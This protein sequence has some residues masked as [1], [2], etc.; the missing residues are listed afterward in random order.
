MK[1][2]AKLNNLRTAPRKVRLVVDLIK[3]SNTEDAIMQ[4]ENLVKGS[5]DDVLKL[6]KSAVANAENN[7]GLDRNNLYVKDVQVG[8]GVKLKRWLPRAFGRAT[9]ILKRSS[10]IYITLDEVEE[11]KNRKTKEEMEK[12]RASRAEME[13]K[14]ENKKVAEKEKDEKEKKNLSKTENIVEKKELD[15]KGSKSGWTNKI[16]RRKSS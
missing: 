2:T 5:S 16:F 7:F 13:K 14:E 12:E 6:L 11:G 8:E 15:R 3:G 4:L 9:G 1:V 10:N